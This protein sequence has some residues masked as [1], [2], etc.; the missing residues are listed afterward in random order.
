M[1]EVVTSYYLRMQVAGPAGRARRHHPHPRRRLDLDRRHGPARAAG[2]RGAGRHHHAHAPDEGKGGERR[3]REDR[4]AAGRHRQGDAHPPRGAGAERR[5]MRYVSTRGGAKARS[6]SPIS[7]SKASRPTAGCTCRRNSRRS[8][9]PELAAMRGMSYRELALAILSQFA[10]DIPARRPEAA[11]RRDLHEE[12][13]RQRRDHAGEEAR[14]GRVSP[15]PVERALARVQ[16]R[17]AAAA[18]ESVRVRRW[19]SAASTSTSSARPRATPG[20]R[21]STRCAARRT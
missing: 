3:D 13:L 5:A 19:R 2:R 16:G 17:R 18:G 14:G 15:R 11:R 7:C 12:G 6:R 21:R 20:R 1:D 8:T 4:E 10:D 9:R